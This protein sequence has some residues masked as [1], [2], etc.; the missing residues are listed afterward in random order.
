MKIH[1]YDVVTKAFKARLRV[2]NGRIVHAPRV[3]AS[4]NR[5]RLTELEDWLT[6]HHPFSWLNKTGDEETTK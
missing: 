6:R 4:F 3:L 2:Q 5:R 1:N